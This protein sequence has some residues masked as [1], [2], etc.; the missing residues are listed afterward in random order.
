[1]DYRLYSYKRTPLLG[2][3]KTF[4]VDLLLS[5]MVLRIFII[6]GLKCTY[7]LYLGKVPEQRYPLVSRHPL[8]SASSTNQPLVLTGKDWRKL[9]SLANSSED[10]V[11]NFDK[12]LEERNKQKLE[13]SET[14][15]RS[16]GQEGRGKVRIY[17]QLSN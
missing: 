12:E 10:D 7:T 8:R 6:L 3:L 14:L 15:K 2:C 17:Y 16:W 13:A 4:I 5:S 11:T 1:M 9:N